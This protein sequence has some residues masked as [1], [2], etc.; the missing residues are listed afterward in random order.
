MYSRNFSGNLFLI[1]SSI[2]TNLIQIKFSTLD[3]ENR[4]VYDNETNLQLDILIN[5]TGKTLRKAFRDF[6]HSNSKNK[7]F[8]C[9]SRL[10]LKIKE[11]KKISII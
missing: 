4:I 10:N 8:I 5:S 11:I 2:S 9:A 7:H 1:C 3:Q 6:L